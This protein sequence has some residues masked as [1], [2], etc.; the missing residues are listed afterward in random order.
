MRRIVIVVIIVCVQ[1]VCL[2]GNIH[3]RRVD[4]SCGLPDN[5]VRCIAQDDEGYMWFGCISGLYKFDGYFFTKIKE[6]HIHNLEFRD[7]EMIVDPERKTKTSKKNVILDNLGNEI[8]T[9]DNISIYYQGQKIDV[10]NPDL[11]RMDLSR[12]YKVIT[13]KDK[14]LVWISSY[15]GGLIRYDLKTKTAMKIKETRTD[16]LVDLYEDRDGNIWVAE[17]YYGATCFSTTKNNMVTLLLNDD[18]QEVHNSQIKV[19]RKVSDGSIYVSTE[20]KLYRFN[21]DMTDGE[22]VSQG[23]DVRDLCYDAEGR[24]WITTRKHGLT[25]DGKAVE[26][27][28]SNRLNMLLRDKDNRMWV[29]TQKGGICLVEDKE[30]RMTKGD[31]ERRGTKIYQFFGEKTIR[32]IIQ[33]SKG[34]IWIGGED[35]LYRF[36]PERILKNKDDYETVKNDRNEDFS[37]VVCLYEDAKHRVWI[38]TIGYGAY[39]MS[40]D[41]RNVFHYST[42]N[43]LINNSVQAITASSDPKYLL[44]A[45]KQGLTRYCPKDGTSRYLYIDDNMLANYYTENNVCYAENDRKLYFGSLA[46]VVQFGKEPTTNI[47]S[48]HPLTVTDTQI[49]GDNLSIHFST[50]NY[51]S[52]DAVKYSYWLEG[53]DKDWSEVSGNSFAEYK[54]LSPGKYIFH[55]KAFE[56]NIWEEK[57][58]SVEIDMPYPWWAS[59]WAIA[60]YIIVGAGIVYV[61]YHQLK[62]V[63]KLRRDISIEQKMTQYKLVFFTNISHEFRTPLT[64][65]KGAVDAIR[66]KGNMPAELRQPISN[67]QS[68]TTRMLRLVNQLLEFRK[69]QNQKLQLHLEETDVVAFLRHLGETMNDIAQGKDLNYYFTTTKKEHNAFVDCDYLDKIVYNLLSNAFKYTPQK[70]M[71]EMRFDVV[72]GNMQ[73]TV[74]DTGVGVPEEKRNRLFDR[75]LQSQYISNSIGIGLNLTAELVKTHHGTIGYAPNPEGGSIFTVTLPDDEA[76]YNEEDFLKQSAITESHSHEGGV[77]VQYKELA[78][79]PLNDNTVL[80]VEDDAELCEYV[81]SILNTYFQVVTAN[82]GEEAMQILKDKDISLVVS[83]VMMPLLDGYHLTEKIRGNSA[84][85]DIPIILLTALSDEEMKLKGLRLGA[86]VFLSKPFNTEELTLNAIRLVRQVQGFKSTKVQE[87]KTTLHPALLSQDKEKRFLQQME[88]WIDAHISASD[89]SID[90]WAEAL[91]MGRTTFYKEVK[92]LT[93]QTPNTYIR[94]RR[95]IKAKAILEE[96]GKTISEV[97]YATGFNTP[98]YFSKCFKE[99]FGIAPSEI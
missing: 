75:Y 8:I 23:Q 25:I 24:L 39:S 52:P 64:I 59:W 45:T 12:K 83:D 68:G 34:Y 71:V 81:K 67:I 5:E 90:N 94:K 13:Q 98:F 80:V 61:I 70:G 73:I 63:Y 29:T 31:E 66:C 58:I 17:E 3:L 47:S 42:S 69:M 19:L 76:V 92:R 2:A 36:L 78:R 95:L 10:F 97:A 62:T 53:F 43:G 65:I 89:I 6:G 85:A 26:G 50:L 82:N 56:N 77:E 49:N 30:R 79:E 4:A 87:F 14:G 44:F 37:E 20:Q 35:G 27:L 86:D 88:S 33:D 60:I 38:G 57:E 74:K 99:E 93:G 18:T 84:L 22:L 32:C 21:Q 9:D 15:G 7:G 91:N 1:S 48:S 28:S 41:A 55:V 51:T 46:G 96:G 54:K 72:D 11:V 40:L 16:Y